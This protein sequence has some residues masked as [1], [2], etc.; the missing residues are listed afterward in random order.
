MREISKEP[1]CRS[2]RLDDSVF[3]RTKVNLPDPPCDFN[4]YDMNECG[5]RILRHNGVELAK[6]DIGNP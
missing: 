4:R 2:L 3:R 5:G 1:R 6:R